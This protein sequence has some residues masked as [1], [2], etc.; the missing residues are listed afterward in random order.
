MTPLPPSAA[1]TEPPPTA[2]PTPDATPAPASEPPAASSPAGD[3]AI[4]VRY[5]V[6][7]DEGLLRIAET[8]GTTRARILD[9]NEG[10]RE[11]E[12]GEPYAEPGQTIIVPVS[13]DMSAEQIE[14][15]PGFVEYVE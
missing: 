5:E 2:L 13:P 1:A 8:F 4:L 12:P 3:A 9:A 6:Q 10:M 7:E 11:R 14:E 15:Q